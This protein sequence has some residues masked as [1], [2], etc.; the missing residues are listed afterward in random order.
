MEHKVCSECGIEINGNPD[1]TKCEEC[2][3]KSFKYFFGFDED[4]SCI[5]EVSSDPGFQEQDDLQSGEAVPSCGSDEPDMTEKRRKLR[6]SEEALVSPN[7]QYRKETKKNYIMLVSIIVC[8]IVGL[9]AAFMFLGNYTNKEI[10]SLISSESYAL[11][12]EKIEA[13]RDKGQQV[14]DLLKDY[15]DACMDAEEFRRVTQAMEVFSDE[16]FEDVEYFVDIIEKI[17]FS[18][19][20]KYAY[21]VINSVYGKND[22]LDSKI[23]TLRNTINE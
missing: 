12:F 3:K 19:R 22:E 18:N 9:S 8:L 1:E 4:E 21:D 15:I 13:L 2:K 16:A 14:D 10:Y 23:D 7:E 11:A 20:S 6:K 5:E 17:L